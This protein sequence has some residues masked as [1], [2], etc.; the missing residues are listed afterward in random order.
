MTQ[1]VEKKALFNISYGLYLLSAEDN[2]I[3]NGCII[4]TAQLVSE[5]PYTMLISVNKTNYTTEI[6]DRSGR[7]NVSV[8]TED[9]PFELFKRFGY[10]SGRENDKFSGFTETAE[11]E[12]GIKYLTSYSNAVISAKVKEK[13]E[14]GSHYVFISEIESSKIT[15]EGKSL[16]YDYYQRNIKPAA[17]PK[18][19]KKGFVCKVCGYVYDGESLPEDFVCP[20]CKHSADYFEEIKG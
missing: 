6:I 4:N 1:S 17:A 10:V 8:L 12:N 14:V 5:N 19:T 13:I 15:G 20:W 3:H 11:T 2:G 7:F 9:T 18:S 16:T